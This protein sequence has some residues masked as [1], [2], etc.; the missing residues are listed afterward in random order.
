MGKFWIW[1]GLTLVASG[2]WRLATTTAA[3]GLKAA[4]GAF[5]KSQCYNCHHEHGAA[6]NVFSQFYPILRRE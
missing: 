1:I 3:T 2:V 5:A 4:A 6:D